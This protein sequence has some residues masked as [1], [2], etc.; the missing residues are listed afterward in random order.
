MHG[1]PFSCVLDK[2][3]PNVLSFT[4]RPEYLALVMTREAYEEEDL[5][6]Q[7]LPQRIIAGRR[8]SIFPWQGDRK[9]FYQMRCYR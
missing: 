4:A 8:S 1:N 5:T 6:S 3:C 2:I 7:V 9:T